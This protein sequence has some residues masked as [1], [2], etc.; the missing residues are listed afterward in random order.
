MSAD[1]TVRCTGCGTLNRIP[2]GRLGQKGRCGQCGAELPAAGKPAVPVDV[3][4]RDFHDK[5]LNSPMPVL[6]EF[7]SPS[8]GHC[9]R[10]D[11][12]LRDIA[13][14]L[15]GRLTVARMDVSAN[16]RTPFDYGIRGTPAFFVIKGGKIAGQFV[17]AM[18]ED[19]L[20][21]KVQSHL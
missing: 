10:M 19:E 12:A 15:A 5:V 17:G 1:I 16:S 6:L 4:D 3:T 13:S 20:M 18:P 9:L 14:K 11:P 8:C 21:R 7:W 2:E